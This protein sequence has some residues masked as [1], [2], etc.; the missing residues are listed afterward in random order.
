MNGQGILVQENRNENENEAKKHAAAAV[1]VCGRTK[2][3]I[4]YN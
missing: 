2:A 3:L 4:R 1:V